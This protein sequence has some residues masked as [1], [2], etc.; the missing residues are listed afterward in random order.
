MNSAIFAFSKKSRLRLTSIFLLI[1]FTSFLVT[2]AIISISGNQNDYST[3]FSMNEEESSNKMP[4][5]NF[6]FDTEKIQSNFESLEFLKKQRNLDGF[7]IDNYS[8]VF[9]DVTS[10]PPRMV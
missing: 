2:P 10:P 6:V 9:L 7:Q 5:S 1:I 3:F 4:K 8:K